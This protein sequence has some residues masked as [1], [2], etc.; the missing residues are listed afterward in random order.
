MTLPRGVRVAWGEV[1]DTVSRREVSR[2]LLSA[3]LPGAT[4]VSR[5]PRCGGDHG[6]IRVSDSDAAVSVSYA[7]GWAVAMVAEGWARAG[8]DVVPADARGLDRVLPGADA[9]AWARVEAA[10]KADG[11]GLEVDPARVEVAGGAGDAWAA[12]VDEGTWVTGHDLA[13]PPGLVAAVAVA[14]E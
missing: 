8:I 11:R 3:L 13:G 6:R 9:R 2:A 1:S 5:C 4:F 7:G 14:T 12:R 10:L